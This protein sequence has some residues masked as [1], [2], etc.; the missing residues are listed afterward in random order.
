MRLSHPRYGILGTRRLKGHLTDN[1]SAATDLID[2]DSGFSTD[3]EMDNWLDANGESGDYSLDDRPPDP[4]PA[5]HP[6]Q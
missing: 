6:S 5:R 2:D 3:E 1:D 4:P